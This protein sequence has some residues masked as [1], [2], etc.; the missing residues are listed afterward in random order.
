[1]SRRIQALRS[2]SS[3]QSVSNFVG[4][5]DTDCAEHTDQSFNPKGYAVKDCECM[6]VRVSLNKARRWEG[7]A[8]AE[9]R[10]PQVGVRRRF[11]NALKGLRRTPS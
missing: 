8:P 5:R 1:M 2:V 10:R 9:P 11:F 6:N 3:V 7:E 4:I